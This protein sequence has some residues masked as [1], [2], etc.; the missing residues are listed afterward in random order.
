MAALPPWQNPRRRQA[1]R[2]DDTVAVPRLSIPRA[3]RHGTELRAPGGHRPP[4]PARSASSDRSAGPAATSSAPARTAVRDRER[5]G[6]QGPGPWRGQY[7]LPWSGASRPMPAA[8]GAARSA[9][10]APGPMPGHLREPRCCRRP[11]VPPGH[12]PA[13]HPANRLED[14]SPRGR[15]REFP[16]PAW[17]RDDRP[18]SGET[19]APEARASSPARWPRPRSRGRLTGRDRPHLRNLTGQQRGAYAQASPRFAAA[20][21]EPLC[22]PG[23][24]NEWEKSRTS[25]A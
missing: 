19:L 3:A 17:L 15:D 25:R 18:E 13:W 8:R 23:R 6:R 10:P 11:A 16:G 24:W 20:A 5:S 1:G 14:H 22:Q 21:A 2:H 7:H 9:R 12:Q 4:A